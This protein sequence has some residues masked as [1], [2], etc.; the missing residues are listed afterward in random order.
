LLKCL[1]IRQR[2]EERSHKSRS[3]KLG[4]VGALVNNLTFMDLQ[5]LTYKLVKGKE[6]GE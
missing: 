3:R 5:F 1:I 4:E 2:L 6:N